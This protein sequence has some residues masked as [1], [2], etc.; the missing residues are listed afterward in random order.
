MDGERE[1]DRQLRVVRPR[2]RYCSSVGVI[3]NYDLRATMRGICSEDLTAVEAKA[4]F[5][6]VRRAAAA[7][8]KTDIAE[9]TMLLRLQ[10]LVAQM[11][12]EV[13]LPVTGHVE[14]LDA[15][16]LTSGARELA[17]ACAYL[18]MDQDLAIADEERALVTTLVTEL[19][20]EEARAQELIAMID[21]L[22]RSA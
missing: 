13:S 10:D 1:A 11:A 3:E 5:D 21:Q 22:V 12:G 17:F 6:I 4:I 20:L 19:G 18:V 14:V 8:Q 9:M 15:T 16:K 2:S 7:D